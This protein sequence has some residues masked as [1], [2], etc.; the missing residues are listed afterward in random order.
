MSELKALDKK[1]LEM[2]K[3]KQYIKSGLNSNTIGNILNKRPKDIEKL[4]RSL[5][6]NNY[7]TRKVSNNGYVYFYKKK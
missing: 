5:L 1:V 4:L 6:E 3:S 7:V 2:L